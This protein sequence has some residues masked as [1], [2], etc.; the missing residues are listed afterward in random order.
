MLK[1]VK[2]TSIA[3][4]PSCRKIATKLKEAVGDTSNK[5]LKTLSDSSKAASNRAPELSPK[6]LEPYRVNLKSLSKKDEYQI[7]R[8]ETQ[9]GPLTPKE[10]LARRVITSLR[11][12]E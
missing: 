12:T 11:V 8:I 7:L 3:N 6:L 9:G 4:R 10:K 5:K 2:S 1:L